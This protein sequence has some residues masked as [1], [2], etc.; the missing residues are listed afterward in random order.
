MP[1][2]T[3]TVEFTEDLNL[4]WIFY[5]TVPSMGAT[6]E[7]VDAQHGPPAHQKGFYRIGVAP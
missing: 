5:T 1:G 2:L 7:F 4:P 3:Y 6:T